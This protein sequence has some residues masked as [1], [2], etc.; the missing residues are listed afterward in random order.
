MLRY[1]GSTPLAA[2]KFIKNNYM[3]P[4]DKNMQQDLSGNPDEL[5]QKE[6]STV[7]P[8][9]ERLEDQDYDGTTWKDE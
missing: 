1:G 9:E 6:E 4:K 3:D 8:P 2:T 5:A 7:P